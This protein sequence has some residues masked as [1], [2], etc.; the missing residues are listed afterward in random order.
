M[1]A[2]IV[3]ICAF[4]AFTDIGHK[5]IVDT[6]RPFVEAHPL[7]VFC[8]MF[9]GIFGLIG[10]MMLT[11]LSSGMA[12]MKFGEKLR[13][14]TLPAIDMAKSSVR[15]IQ[16]S[17][18]Q[19]A[20]TVVFL[21]EN[22]K[23]S[24]KEETLAVDVP[25]ILAKN[26]DETKNMNKSFFD[27]DIYFSLH[28]GTEVPINIFDMHTRLYHASA[29]RLAQPASIL[30]VERYLVVLCSDNSILKNGLV[31]RAD[32]GDVCPFMLAF[33][34]GFYDE[35]DNAM[36]VFGIDV[37]Y[38]SVAENGQTQK[39]VIPSDCIYILQY[40]DDALHIKELDRDSIDIGLKSK[41]KSVRVLYK[42]LEAAYIK[43]TSRSQDFKNGYTREFDAEVLRTP[44]DDYAAI[45]NGTAKL[46]N[47][48]AE[49]FAEWDKEDND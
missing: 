21:T 34:A 30:Y 48:T 14:D 8:I 17:A 10:V 47:N 24:P 37:E 25:G 7:L 41:S 2:F 4:T 23:Y 5:G 38:S 22:V 33:E 46:F 49:M 16:G 18:R 26:Y 43:H 45:E 6:A 15:I 1:F 20:G 31:Y 11:L 44:E 27:I 28:N 35:A 36:A 39:H 9:F 12:R 42:S 19:V 29:G 13:D 32:P 3:G 40:I